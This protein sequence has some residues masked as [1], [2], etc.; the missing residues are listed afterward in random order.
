MERDAW[1]SHNRTWLRG[2]MKSEEDAEA[3]ADIIETWIQGAREPGSLRFF[4]DH[5]EFGPYTNNLSEPIKPNPYFYF[6]NTAAASALAYKLRAR[7]RQEGMRTDGVIGATVGEER[8]RAI[9]SST[10]LGVLKSR[11]G[12]LYKSYETAAGEEPDVLYL[13]LGV[14][15]EGNTEDD[16]CDYAHAFFF[17]ANHGEVSAER[18]GRVRQVLLRE[19]LV[20]IHPELKGENVLSA[21]ICV[22]PGLLAHGTHANRVVS[23]A[24]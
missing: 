5:C 14:T 10:L 1:L 17:E 12:D 13:D 2:V 4:Y 6:K 18:L 20:R 11:L 3:L 15:V 7:L 9:A 21:L 23:P 24:E 8:A 16:R 19:G 22:P